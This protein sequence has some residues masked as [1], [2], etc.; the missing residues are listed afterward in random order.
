[1]G[2]A[3][4]HA[5]RRLYSTASRKS[6]LKS[7]DVFPADTAHSFAIHRRFLN[8]SD[9]NGITP[10]KFTDNIFTPLLPAFTNWFLPT[11]ATTSRLNIPYLLSHLHPQSQSQTPTFDENVRPNADPLLPIEITTPDGIVEQGMLPYTAF[12]GYLSAP[13]I[14][15]DSPKLYLAQHPPPDFLLPDVP[16]PF[17]SLGFTIRPQQ[18][19][20]SQDGE[21]LI[22]GEG[23]YED[24]SPEEMVDIYSSSLW[25][26]R[27][28]MV[29]NTPLHRDP[30]D[31]IFVQLS[32]RKVIRCLPPH[33]GDAV[34][35]MLAETGWTVSSDPNG[36][37]RD[38]LLDPREAEVFDAIVWGG[39]AEEE[40][41]KGVRREYWR[42]VGEIELGDEMY[43]SVVERGEGVFIPRGWWHAVRSL[44]PGDIEEQ[45]R[46][47][48]ATVVASM[49][50]WFR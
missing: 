49:N 8:S 2:F 7:F 30:N 33:I 10:T 29:T 36:R 27:A 31:N 4:R 39:V 45:E 14:H 38:G 22:N 35:R 37:I 28:S 13:S 18:P 17:S 48:V 47:E 21:V 43:E 1:M 12:L 44:V 16:A 11:S 3:I 26:S 50:W 40:I 24:G 46:G 34:F 32:G 25:M 15:P 23:I 41:M 6:K 9:S 19:N 5:S 42:D 20:I